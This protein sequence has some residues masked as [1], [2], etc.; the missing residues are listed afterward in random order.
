MK[1]LKKKMSWGKKQ[2]S[3]IIDNK[4]GQTPINLHKNEHLLLQ[5][6]WQYDHSDCT[7]I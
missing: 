6:Y 4:N 3:K 2:L 7:G 1:V 5:S